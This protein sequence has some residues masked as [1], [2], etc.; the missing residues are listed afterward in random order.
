MIELLPP[1]ISILFGSLVIVAIAWFYWLSRSRIF[2]ILT[3]VWVAIQ[4]VLSAA[5]VYQNTTLLPPKLLLYGILPVLIFI[6]SIF[7]TSQGKKFIAQLPLKPLT[8]LHTIRI[9]VELVLYLL[10]LHQLVPVY[11]TFEGTNFDII[12]GL[13]APFVAIFAFNGK[14]LKKKLLVGWNIFGLALLLN[15][16]ITAMLALPTPMQQISLQQPNVAVL[17]FPFSLLPTVVVPLVLFAH[18]AAIKQ[19]ISTRS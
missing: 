17:Y 1:A 19:L 2:L 10:F 14:S 11:M 18:L 6:V 7:T 3:T 9:L 8:Y 12:T 13:T 4:T 16:V 5:G 15:V